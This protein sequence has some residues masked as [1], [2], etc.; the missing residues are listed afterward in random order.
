MGRRIVG[1]L[2]VAVVAA[3]SPR[4]VRGAIQEDLTRLSLEALM[5][6]RVTTAARTAQPVADTPA[7]VTVLTAEDLRR[8]GAV[9]LA[10]ALR[11]VPGVHVGRLDA[12][13]W[14]LSARGFDSRWANKLLVMIDGR[15][16]YSP[17]FAG[18]FWDVQDV[19]LEDVE[20]IEVI[21]GPGAALWG[22]NAVNGVVHVITRSA[23]DTQGAYAEMAGG[24]EERASGAV[25]YGSRL[26]ESVWWRA[27]AKGFRRD[28]GRSEAGHAAGDGWEQVRGGFRVDGDTGGRGT[29]T[30][31]G[32]AY[33]GTSGAAYTLPTPEPGVFARIAEDVDVAGW[34]LLGRWEVGA[35]AGGRFRAQG[36]YDLAI[37]RDVPAAARVETWD[38]DLQH[39]FTLGRR[40]EVVWGGGVRL[41]RDR[42]DGTFVLRFDPARR[43]TRLWSLFLRDEVSLVP[44]RLRAIV[45]GRLEHNSYTGWEWQPDLRVLWHPVRGHTLWAAVSR[46]VRSPSRLE[47]DGRVVGALLG[48]GDAGNPFP[49]EWKGML[50]GDGRFSSERVVAWQGGYRVEPAPSVSAEATAFLHRYRG[51]RTLE[52]VRIGPDPEDPGR[53]LS[54]ARPDNRMDGRVWGAELEARWSVTPRWRWRLAYTWLRVELDAEGSTDPHAELDEGKTPRHQA[55]LWSFADLPGNV[56]LDVGLGYVGARERRSLP[57]YWDLDVRIAWEPSPGIEVSVVGRALLE[58]S[59]AEFPREDFLRL[60][61]SEMERGVYA[62][63]SGRF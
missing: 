59:R 7:P 11:L 2:A 51:L 9:T 47:A 36:F 29:W 56:E 21:R 14:A 18:V 25:R 35:P 44:R 55:A 33:R 41:V 27:Y 3:V 32:D 62:K 26:G 54:V 5:E 52:V 37:R 39:R 40:Q 46:A 53:V 20:R 42:T 43:T 1:W 22:A 24:T 28:G 58:R 17:L 57:P 15:T 49:A 50:V 30:L 60:E 16:V 4:G 48:P 34:S 23:R 13:T 45:A 10:D 19:L 61:T 63:I 12:N 31:Q 6:L 38:L 8:T